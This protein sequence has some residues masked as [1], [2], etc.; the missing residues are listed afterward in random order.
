VDTVL[1]REA[2]TFAEPPSARDGKPNHIAN[3]L[4]ALKGALVGAAVTKISAF[5]EEVLPGFKQEWSKTQAGRNLNRSVTAD[6]P[7]WQKASAVGAD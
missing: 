2:R 7:S 6:S 5:I 1:D 4:N 3:T